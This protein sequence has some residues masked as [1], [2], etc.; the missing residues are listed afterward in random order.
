MFLSSRISRYLDDAVMCLH[1][2]LNDPLHIVQRDVFVGVFPGQKKKTL[3]VLCR[4]GGNLEALDYTCWGPQ[5]FGWLSSAML[6][7]GLDPLP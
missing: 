3:A 4:N 1:V 7:D 6:L 2:P 5:Q